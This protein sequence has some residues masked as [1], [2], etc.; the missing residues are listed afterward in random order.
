MHP[1]IEEDAPGD[2]PICG[3]GLEPKAVAVRGAEDEPD[4]ELVDM[5]RRFR[6]GLALGL[7]VILLAMRPM[8]GLPIDD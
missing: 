2:C 4:P 3:L 6:V 5:T 7:P 1:Q 8:V